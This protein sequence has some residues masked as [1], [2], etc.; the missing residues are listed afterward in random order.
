MLYH[1]NA[2]KSFPKIIA[3][4]KNYMKHV[5]EM[6]GTEAPK[7]PVV[8]MK[9]WSSINYMPKSLHLPSAKIHRIDH[10]LELGVFISKGGSN[11]SKENAM[12]HVGG[13]FIG[14]DFTDRGNVLSI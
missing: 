14:I 2:I 1:N 11:I 13:Y 9:P 8:F 3:I 4:G 6:G 10:E 7:S 5:K 12:S